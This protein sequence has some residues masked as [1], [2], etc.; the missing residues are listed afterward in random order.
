MLFRS[1]HPGVGRVCFFG[2]LPNS[3][4]DLEVFD[5]QSLRLL[6][7]VSLPF[8][9]DWIAQAVPMLP[10]RLAFRLDGGA[11]YLVRSSLL[12][13]PAALRLDSLGNATLRTHGEASEP[14][15]IGVSSDLKNWTDLGTF[16]ADANG[17]LQFTDTNTTSLPQRFYRIDPQ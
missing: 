8:V 17:Q 1:I 10:D 11:I 9:N 7:N 16:Q 14:F 5:Q 4:P 13:L 15:D 6:G 3:A 12:T 2:G